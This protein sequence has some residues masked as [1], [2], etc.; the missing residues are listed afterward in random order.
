MCH[1]KC[2]INR[3]HILCLFHFFVYHQFYVLSEMKELR[4]QRTLDSFYK[5]DDD[6]QPST[7]AF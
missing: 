1:F 2:Q 6:S 3:L 5:D 4:I 7:S